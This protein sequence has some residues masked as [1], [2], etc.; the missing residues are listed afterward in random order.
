MSYHYGKVASQT[1]FNSNNQTNELVKNYV[2]V[3]T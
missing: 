2:E 1:I 3:T